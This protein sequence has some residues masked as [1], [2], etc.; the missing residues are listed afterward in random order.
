M[1][2]KDQLEASAKSELEILEDK[3]LELLQEIANLKDQID[4]LNDTLACKMQET[5]QARHSMWQAAARP[6]QADVCN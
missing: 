2:R 1:E 6:I 4:I 3:E 5:G